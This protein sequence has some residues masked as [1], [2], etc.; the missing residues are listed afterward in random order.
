M[1]N[2]I[3]AHFMTAAEIAETV[4]IVDALLA[5]QV[6]SVEPEK[7]SRTVVDA[8]AV[9]I[10]EAWKNRH[11]TAID[12]E[13]SCRFTTLPDKR[14]QCVVAAQG[15]TKQIAGRSAMAQITKALR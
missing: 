7:F 10:I 13:A 2:E 4:D 6:N 3:E 8:V 14:I 1:L 12:D 9:N 11:K 15:R 5:V